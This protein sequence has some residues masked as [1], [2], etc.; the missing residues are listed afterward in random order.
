MHESIDRR[1]PR[2]TCK[3]IGVRWGK[4]KGW[5][6]GPVLEGLRPAAEQAADA[7]ARRE[8]VG[9]QRHAQAA[10]LLE[11]ECRMLAARRQCPHQRGDVL[12]GADRLTHRQH[13][14]RIELA[15]GGDEAV[16]VLAGVGQCCGARVGRWA[17]QPR[18]A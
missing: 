1:V 14:A 2:A 15:V 12:I 17:H 13:I 9:H 11:H 4:A 10:H 3:A 7:L 18:R 8:Q 6:T 5:R 16:Q